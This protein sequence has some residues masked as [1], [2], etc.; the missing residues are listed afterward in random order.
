MVKCMNKQQIKYYIVSLISVVAGILL[1]QY[2]KFLAVTHL[3]DQSPYIII[4][5]VFELNYLENKGAAFGIMQNQRWFFVVSFVVVILI[6]F[7]LYIKLPTSQRFIPLHI[8]SALIVAG[9]I[10]NLIDRVRLGYVVDF[11]YFSLIDFPIFNVA[12]IF[13]VIGVITLAIVILFVYTEK[14]LDD[15]LSFR[16][17][18]QNKG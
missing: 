6:I 18:N 10:G 3:K 11:F 4:K 9:A 1:D 5:N 12:D 8:C 15:I 14:E 2:T 7:L 17:T 13:V 16:K